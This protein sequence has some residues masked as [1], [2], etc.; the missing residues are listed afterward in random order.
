MSKIVVYPAFEQPQACGDFLTKLCWFL[1][2]A[3]DAVTTI[4]LFASFPE[5]PKEVSKELD[6]A[7]LTSDASARLLQKVQLAPPPADRSDWRA[8]LDGADVI[9]VWR[10]AKSEAPPKSS[11]TA[12]VIVID[13]ADSGY[14]GARLAA[15]AKSLETDRSTRLQSSR[16]AYSA[17]KASLSKKTGYLIGNGP[18]LMECLRLPLDDGHA[19][20]CND[21]VLDTQVMEALKPVAV[22]VADSGFYAVP[23]HFG[24]SF[25]QALRE[26]MEAQGLYL[27]VSMKDYPLYLSALPDSL[28]ARVVGLPVHNQDRLS[29]DLD[30]QF[31]VASFNHVMPRLMLPLGASLFDDIRI[32]GMDGMPMALA[33]SAW[34]GSAAKSYG[35]H[36]TKADRVPQ[37]ALE[38]GQA[39]HYVA[40]TKQLERFARALERAGKTVGGYTASHIPALR[41]RGAPEPLPASS[42]FEE[43]ADA[44]VLSLTPDMRDRIG[45]YWNYEQRLAPKVE[46]GG[47][48]YWIA[49]SV[50]WAAQ[51]D[52]GEN[53]NQYLDCSLYTYS[54]TLANKPDESPQRLQ[55]L[56]RKVTEEF[57]MVVDRALASCK[58]RL[59]VYM[60]VG[61]LEHAAI[62]YEIALL[63]PRVSVQVN[64]FWFRSADAWAPWFLDRW[65]WLLKAADQDPR[66]AITCM[67]AHQRRQIL[68]RSG[69]ALP[70]AAHP[71]P[72]VDDE[73]AWS[74]LSEEIP[75]RSKIRVFFPSA[76]RTEKG[77]ELLSETARKLVDEL[78]DLDLELIFRT[79]PFE[80]NSKVEEDPLHRYVTVLEGHIEEAT[81]IEVLRSCHV[82]VLPYLPPDFADRTSGLVIDALYAGAPTIVV[83]GTYLAEVAQK[84]GCGVVVDRGSAEEI[85]ESV[86]ELVERHQ[87]RPWDFRE[88]AKLYYRANSWQ[89]LASELIKS[90]L[91]ADEAYLDFTPVESSEPAVSLLGP[92]PRDEAR[93]ADPLAAVK[94]CLAGQGQPP[95]GFELLGQRADQ[96]I[97]LL[98]PEGKGLT[99]AG[100]ERAS[101]RAKARLQKLHPELASR[102]RIEQLSD[103]EREDALIEQVKAYCSTAKIKSANI[104]LGNA[105]AFAAEAAELTCQLKARA[106]VIA[107]DDAAGSNHREAAKQ[108]AEA[109]YLVLVAED[110]PHIGNET[111]SFFRRLATYPFVS[112]LPWARGH[113][114][115]L[116]K[117]LSLAAVREAFL[118]TGSNLFHHIRLDPQDVG[119]EILADAR[120]LAEEALLAAAK[121]PSAEWQL[122][123]LEMEG[124]S[125][126]GFACLKE[127]DTIRIHRSSL[128]GKAEEGKPLTI[129]I[130][131]ASY[132]RRF[133][134]LLLADKK[135]E[136]LAEA[137][138][139]LDSGTLL[140]QSTQLEGDG[141]FAA[142]VPVGKRGEE[143]PT[144]RAWISLPA[145]PRSETVQAQIVTLD[146]WSGS[147]QTTGESDKGVLA[148]N[149]LLEL[150]ATPSLFPETRPAPAKAAALPRPAPVPAAPLPE[151]EATVP[152]E[153]AAAAPE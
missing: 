5:L 136:V 147:R 143:E 25:R 16:E 67:T 112:D 35:D 100:S 148:R 61:S 11:A 129:S 104:L 92:L 23:T 54:Y 58:G 91:A 80:R 97:Q 21:L 123:G 120:P 79:S 89:R 96:V 48:R 98:S 87:Q 65:M 57:S 33:S 95:A 81:F 107:F 28:H 27:I 142:C 108:L 8:L 109:G 9:L 38:G 41:R 117:S 127:T 24:G 55:Q 138:F 7:I 99:V 70:V 39:Q 42:G 124:T 15:L 72:L 45:H 17:L 94:A 126:D 31:A 141:L 59:H 111:E 132:G 20:V 133:V 34:S 128:R 19:V 73:N 6:P 74:L 153:E 12:K 113:L 118:S 90:S 144:Y 78:G 88:A 63:R 152:E 40:F 46:A 114:V 36:R 30:Q 101:L 150:S 151:E 86:V 130:E 135:N 106:A 52:P 66:L 37:A 105:P 10:K 29:L 53:A 3:T 18:S 56:A 139:D 116:P 134:A 4:S 51:N 131:L 121:L 68:A 82:V 47:I 125:E 93:K 115:A 103:E 14:G 1:S 50:E 32:C 44:T 76:N 69:I 145:Y 122:A 62:L 137:V 2:P 49:A 83:R 26:R 22:A 146:K 60:Y 64:L 77:V 149:F 119:A 13:E 75:E 102:M 71:S 110:H 84:Y 43:G 140:Q 85:A